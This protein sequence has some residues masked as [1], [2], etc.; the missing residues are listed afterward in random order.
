[1]RFLA[2]LCVLASCALP[3]LT[4]AAAEID[5]ALQAD[6]DRAF[7][8]MYRNPAD[9]DAALRY[10]EVATRMRDYEGAI[11][12]LERMLLYNPDLPNIRLE[13]AALYARLGAYDA[14]RGYLDG[15][16][17][18]KLPPDARARRGQLLA[19]IDRRTSSSRLSG[20]VQA[21][22]RYQTN[23]GSAPASGTIRSY[24]LDSALDRQY[25][26]RSDGNFFLSTGIAHQYDLGWG[27]G[28]AWETN[29]VG[30]ATQQL[31]ATRFDLLFGE[32]DSG[33]RIALSAGPNPPSVRPYA[34]LGA[35][36][37]ADS[38]YYTS[39]GGG[40]SLLYPLTADL[41]ADAAGEA[42][43]RNFHSSTHFSTADDKTGELYVARLRLRYGV[44]ADHVLGLSGLFARDRSDDS[45]EANREWTLAAEHAWTLPRSIIPDGKR[46]LLVSSLQRTW[47]TYDEADPF[48]DPAVTREDRQWLA[49]MTLN[50]PFGDSWSAFLQ[51]QHDWTDSNL[52][53]YRYRNASGMLGVA[54]GF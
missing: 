34:L 13:L 54:Y 20:V 12:A 22:M 25:A 53:N 32:I 28:A 1:M 21:G 18:D 11:G 26:K 3:N 42:R 49:S 50:L 41:V 40:A 43:K 30:Y 19:D 47:R 38:I 31:K 45:P 44:S 52:V 5:P 29:L 15:L 7:A 51:L 23:V 46:M 35:V 39:A 6:Y 36:G 16:P 48:V 27:H 37:L 9:L 8:T 14:A 2:A 33:P 24:G 17:E 4:A 10:A